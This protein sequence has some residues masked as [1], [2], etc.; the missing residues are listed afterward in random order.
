MKL[1]KKVKYELYGTQFG[2]ALPRNWKF[3]ALDKILSAKKI[4][5]SRQTDVACIKRPSVMLYF[6][7]DSAVFMLKIQQKTVL[8]LQR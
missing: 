8:D 3:A 5:A 1:K 2:R 4:N 7:S 6:T